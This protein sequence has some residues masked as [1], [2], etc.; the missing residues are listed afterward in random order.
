MV[1]RTLDEWT[2]DAITEL[3]DKR[4]GEPEAFDFKEML[5]HSSD[6]AGKH[7]LRK[8]CC[9]F[10]NS[11][12]GFIVFGVKDESRLPT[13][14]R[15]VGLEPSLDFNKLFSDY[16]NACRPSVQWEPKTPPMRLESGRLIQVAFIPRSWRGPHCVKPS[17]GGEGYVFPKRVTGADDEMSYEEVR[18]SF[19]GYYEKRIKLQLLRSELENILATANSMRPGGPALATATLIQTFSLDVLESVLGETYTILAGE[20]ALL[21]ALTA[22]R[23]RGR[24]VNNKIQ[25]FLP[26]LSMPLTNVEQLNYTHNHWVLMRSQELST[27]VQEALRLL[28]CIIRA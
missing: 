24:L 12:G 3:L 20:G 6:D 19:L 7:R 22:I 4:C 2:L 1:P 25:S 18:L 16:A 21:Q 8:A 11:S 28:D 26:V 27:D 23:S 13:T 14:D 15:L 17:N 9:A 10:A 5:P